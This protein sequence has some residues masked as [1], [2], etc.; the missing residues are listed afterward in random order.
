LDATI[1]ADA[2][3]IQ[4]NAKKTN[5]DVGNSSNKFKVTGILIGGQKPVDY[6]FQQRSD[7]TTFYTIY[8]NSFEHDTN[9][10]A[11][12][13][14][15]TNNTPIYTLAL[16][17]KSATQNDDENAIV[18]IAVEFENNSGQT[19][20]GKDNEQIPNGCRFYLIG[21]LDPNINTTQKYT[22]D[23]KVADPANNSLSDVTLNNS[24]VIKKAFVQDYKTIVNLKIANLNNAYNT[25]P[26]LTLPQLE[27][28]LSVDL[29][30]KTGI[31]QVIDME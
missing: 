5:F 4:D 11:V 12:Y 13:L 8:D 27:M 21:T 30:W 15:S 18:K 26:D 16:E 19:L 24:D 3:T 10:G 17:T 31:T 20:I 9:I 14:R 23:E 25:L 28:G 22:F 2:A 7:A 29:S 1:V 6:K